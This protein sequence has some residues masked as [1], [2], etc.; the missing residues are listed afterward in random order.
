MK[1][2]A[3]RIF[4]SAICAIF[5][6]LATLNPSTAR[7][8]LWEDGGFESDFG[9]NP[10][11]SFVGA[12]NSA[13]EGAAPNQAT[14][15]TLIHDD[16]IT[17]SGKW[18]EDSSRAYEGDRMFWLRPYD[19]PDTICVGHRFNNVLQEGI[20]YEL[21]YKFAAF[22]ENNSGGSSTLTT[23][24]VAELS[25][26]DTAGNFGTTELAMSFDDGTVTNPNTNTFSE[27]PVQDW[28]NLTWMTATA[29]FVAP[30]S[31]GQAIYVWASMTNDSNGML[32]DG[33]TLRA[34]PEPTAGFIVA[35]MGM[36]T[37]VSRRRK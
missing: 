13:T 22:D 8:D 20:T 24:P 1:V 25:S 23:K 5:L 29:T 7:A 6:S 9:W 2:P 15:F 28:N 35:A 19:D 31:N 11:D 21:S 3:S 14:F 32:I 10:V 4:A 26:F 34:V 12:A 18:V 33:I 30:P 36:L 17:E 16:L 37:L 27:F